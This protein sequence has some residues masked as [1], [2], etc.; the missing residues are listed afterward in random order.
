M[1]ATAKY[2]FDQ[3]FARNAAPEEKPIPR[4]EYLLKLAEAERA[5]FEKAEQ[6]GLAVAARHMAIAL[7]RIAATMERTTQALGGIQRHMESQAIQ[8][9]TAI[10]RKLAPALV[11]REP[12][13]EIEALAAECFGQI[14][15]APHVI[16]RINEA[17][18][19]TTRQRVEEIARNRGY[20]GRL[21][22][23]GEPD[24]A[25]G[26]CKI[27][28]ADGGIIRD[29][30]KIEL[31]ISKAIGRYLGTENEATMPELG[32]IA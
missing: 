17:L 20:E 18:L 7:E 4:A 28:W 32:D 9:A 1:A 23:I 11:T 3:D 22:V 24:I 13:A 10:A 2:M 25:V 27:E 30:A 8:L 26:D 29:Q 5:G 19:D 14:L 15:S 6:E 31:I 16:V 21:V 12:M